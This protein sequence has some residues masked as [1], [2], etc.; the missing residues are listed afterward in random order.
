MVKFV[1]RAFIGTLII[2]I[3]SISAYASADF[4]DKFDSKLYLSGYAG[5]DLL[6]R[7]DLIVPF[8]QQADRNA[9]IY[10]QSRVS[11][12][13]VDNE[14]FSATPWT[15]TA[16]LGYR[17][18]VHGGSALLGGFVLADLSQSGRQG[19]YFWDISPGV[20]A[21]GKV[22][23]FRANGYFPVSDKRWE[24]IGFAD[25]LNIPDTA[26]FAGNDQFGNYVEI[27]KYQEIAPGGDAEIG[28][29]L[30]KINNV[31]V[32]GYVG[33]YY[34]DT[35]GN[36]SITGGS[37]RLTVQPSGF[38]ELSANDTYD[39]VSHNTFMLGMRLRLN[40]IFSS[41][42]QHDVIEDRDLS[43]RLLDPI[44]RNLGNL[45]SGSSMLANEGKYKIFGRQLEYDNVHFFDGNKTTDGKG[46]YEDPFSYKQYTQ[47]TIDSIGGTNLDSAKSVIVDSNPRLYFNYGTYTGNP[48]SINLYD[49]QS[50]W[51]RTQNY[52]QA[53]PTNALPIISGQLNLPGNNTVD[54]LT[55]LNSPL[56]AAKNLHEGEYFSGMFI[57]GGNVTLS[58]DIIG[59]LDSAHGYNEAINLSDQAGLALKNTTVY[60]YSEYPASSTFE[61]A[62]ALYATD[63]AKIDSIE[64]STLQAMSTNGS[65]FGVEFDNVGDVTIG[66]ITNSNFIGIGQNGY[67]EGLFAHSDTGSV[68]IAVGS[69]ITNSSF[70]GNDSS[71][72]KEGYGFDAEAAGNVNIGNIISTTPSQQTPTYSFTGSGRTAYGF[73]VSSDNG[74]INVGNISNYGFSASSSAGIAIA[75]DANPFTTLSAGGS[76]NIAKGGVIKNSSFSATAT[77]GSARGL[78]VNAYQNI[79]LGNLI[80]TNYDDNLFYM[81][82]MSN[83][84]S[85]YG[86]W[87]NSAYGAVTVGNISNYYFAATS[88][89]STAY[90]FRATS[91]NNPAPTTILTTTIGNIDNSKFLGQSGSSIGTGLVTNFNTNASASNTKTSIGTITNSSFSGLG[92]ASSNSLQLNGLE[93]K[94]G[95]ATYTDG[96]VLKNTLTSTNFTGKV[97][98]KIDGGAPICSS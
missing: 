94:V 42:P 21:L 92:N 24:K 17:Q 73:F 6:G 88:P 28:R 95:G 65:A 4:G 78:F 61:D 26:T 11:N 96:S 82:A 76:V 63:S 19:N 49:G 12:N 97:C 14:L 83:G 84:A 9:F 29:K 57:T 16:G 39:H 33:G 8:W 74:D 86:V 72:N 87:L 47:T 30:F 98:I 25:Q 40:D 70:Y 64:N 18:I 93:V 90:G 3:F 79:T 20:E 43:E 5:T 77:S 1:S 58:N 50:M 10:G 48:T 32:K 89:N 52:A 41:K 75:F 22:W 80:A 31:L 45:G 23:D 62:Y 71:N 85:S 54:S 81:K 46:T 66:P 53:A 44:E 35:K 15:A 55:I 38:V 27:M 36:G 68:N 2:S 69:A 56:T 13:D 37:A 7:A 51:G 60:G 67:G 91:N 34:F 59:A